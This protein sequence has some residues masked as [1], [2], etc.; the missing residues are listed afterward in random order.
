MKKE[1]KE[2]GKGRVKVVI[3]MVM[4]VVMMVMGCNS[5]GVKG[6]GAA[7]GGGSGAKS[8]SEV[9]L[10]VGRSAENVF[11]SFLELVSG[12]LG[13][14]VK[15]TT[16]KNE[17]GNYFYGLGK[18]LEIAS[19]ELEKVAEKA[20]A[21]VDKEGIL[22][23]GIRAAVDTA[24]T[25]LNI[26][27]GHL[28]SLKGI[29]GDKKVIDV[30][31]NQNGVAADKDVLKVVYKALKGMVEVAKGEKVKEPIASDVTL[32]Q[33]SIG[34]DAKDGAKILATDAAGV[35]VGEKAALIVSSVR[36]EEM[37]AS[38]VN[39]TEGDVKELGAAADVNTTPLG[40]A[41]GGTAANVAN[42]ASKAGA[43]SGGIALRSLVKEG[44]LA[45]HNDDNDHKVVQAV[46]I[47]AVNK[48][49][50]A[51]EEIVKKTVK[52]VIEKVKQEV[53]KAREPKAVGQQ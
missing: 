14:A 8:L 53:D 45:T 9:L 31:K 36:G 27:K 35:A 26:L 13:F 6:E 48:L 52:N 41:V 5:G 19:G 30:A 50:V 39:S 34:V 11:Y 51:V 10:E 25:T 24:K 7:G 20:S 21:D 33:A 49:L 1:K 38:I 47:S 37:L 3:I 2:E 18:K 23:K 44:K 40:F 4:M 22:N 16:K 29:G 15:A 43:V 17:V 12:S 42:A 32:A 46:G 28:E